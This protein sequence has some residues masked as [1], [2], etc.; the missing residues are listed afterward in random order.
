M[1][2]ISNQKDPDVAKLLN[3]YDSLEKR[4]SLIEARLGASDASQEKL[5]EE[6][7]EI[8]IP[9]FGKGADIEVRIG[10]QGLAWLGNIVLVFGIMFL[11]T[12]AQNLGYSLLP[13]ILGYML[14]AG[15]FLVAYKIR[16]SLSHLDFK[17]RGFYPG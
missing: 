14:T 7:Q 15:I 3:S 9:S 11:M 10:S 4:I 1:T 17:K 8:D 6:Y 16:K 12:Y 2:N 13:S 5:L